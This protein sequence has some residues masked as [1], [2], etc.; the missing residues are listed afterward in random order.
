MPPQTQPEE[1]PAPGGAGQNM[2]SVWTAD[3]QKEEHAQF[4]PKF[5]SQVIPLSPTLQG[6]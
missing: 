6:L 2:Y 1:R 3:Y 5:A 4:L